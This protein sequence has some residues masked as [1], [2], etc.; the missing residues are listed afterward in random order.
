MVPNH[1]ELLLTAARIYI[2]DGLLNGH[3][4][5]STKIFCH[6]KAAF[7]RDLKAPSMAQALVLSL[8]FRRPEGRR[9]D[10]RMKPFASA[11]RKSLFSVIVARGLRIK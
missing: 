2:V 7:S 3:T 1:F 9:L 6:C 5:R 11:Y 10:Q 4:A 8:P